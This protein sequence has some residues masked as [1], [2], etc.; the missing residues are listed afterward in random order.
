MTHIDF[1]R[2]ISKE[3][4]TNQ[5]RLVALLW[6]NSVVSGEESLSHIEL[7]KQIEE[8]NLGKQNTN[9]AKKHLIKDK[10]VVKN[11]KT[12]FSINPKYSADLKSSY[13][14]YLDSIPIEEYISEY[15]PLKLF[16]NSR[17]YTKRVVKQINGS[18]YYSMYDCCSVMCRR[19][20]ETLIIE[21]YENHR[22]ESKIKYGDGNFFP[23]SKLI[24]T[25]VEDDDLHIGRSTQSGLKD[26]K[27]LGDLSAHNRRFN[28]RKDDLDL[29]QSG[30]RVASEELLNIAGQI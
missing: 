20:I 21:S 28:A 7:C 15:L 30:I 6:F 3:K 27:K 2:R 24:D 19:L 4:L 10:R 25:I 9:R 18:Y 22:I 14:D 16:S 8:A 5:E 26:F 1:L 29:V 12:K 17:G 13:Q 11:D 23:L